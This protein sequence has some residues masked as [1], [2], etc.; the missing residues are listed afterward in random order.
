M[1]QQPPPPLPPPPPPPPSYGG[2]GA[3]GG[4]AYAQPPAER[5]KDGIPYIGSRISL[6][7]KTDIRY[8]GLLF[9]IDTRQ[10]MV[11]LQN[12]RSF[13]T[14]GRR[15]EHIPPSP[16]ILQF[17]TF[18]ASEIKDLH[19]SEAA[20][21]PPQ[22]GYGYGPPPPMPQGGMAPH[23]PSMPTA[24]APPPPISPVPPPRVPSPIKAAAAPKSAHSTPVLLTPGSVSSAQARVSSPRMQQQQQASPRRQVQESPVHQVQHQY[25]ERNGSHSHNRQQN[26]GSSTRTIPG[27]GGHLLKRKERR[28]PGGDQSDVAVAVATNGDFNFEEALNDFR[29]DEE[30]AKIPEKETKV[31]QVARDATFFAARA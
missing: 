18:K 27:M 29:K 20:A 31:R 15:A 19:V 17:A 24:P 22:M 13:G 5:P 28:V 23:P 30:Y 3:P 8:E 2:G 12:V 11:A 9:N 1:Q 10:S 6:I 14:E 4:P 16:Q 7:S 26:A 21:P 25:T